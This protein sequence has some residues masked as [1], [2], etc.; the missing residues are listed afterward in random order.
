MTNLEHLKKWREEL[1]EQLHNDVVVER[2]VQRKAIV[3]KSRTTLTE[4]GEIQNKLKSHRNFLKYINEMIEEVQ[5][6]GEKTLEDIFMN[7][8]L[9]EK[10]EEEK[11]VEANQAE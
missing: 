7:E 1:F 6:S 3:S 5:K 2:Y 11:P 4:L 8:Q 10:S 9:E